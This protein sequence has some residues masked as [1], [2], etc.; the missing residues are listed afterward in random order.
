M[1]KQMLKTVEIKIPEGSTFLVICETEDD[2]ILNGTLTAWAEMEIIME[3]LER[4]G[5]TKK[6]Y[7]D[8]NFPEGFINSLCEFLFT[9]I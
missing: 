2:I 6:E 1:K 8:I 7:P 9:A 3:M 4:L 5:S